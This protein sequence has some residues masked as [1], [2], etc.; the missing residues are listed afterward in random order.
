ML[1]VKEQGIPYSGNHNEYNVEMP[2]IQEVKG[3]RRGN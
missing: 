1:I 2:P 3:E